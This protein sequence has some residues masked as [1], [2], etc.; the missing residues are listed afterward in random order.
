MGQSVRSVELAAKHCDEQ[1]ELLLG[2]STLRQDNVR[3]G[4]TVV[5]RISAPD[6]SKFDT[7]AKWVLQIN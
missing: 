5:G 6:R 3:S 1:A 4:I 2:A 7:T